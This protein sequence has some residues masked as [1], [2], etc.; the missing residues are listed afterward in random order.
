MRREPFP[1]GGE[2]TTLTGSDKPVEI[3]ARLVAPPAGILLCAIAV[4]VLV[5]AAGVGVLADISARTTAAIIGGGVAGAVGLAS[6]NIVGL[7]C[8]RLN[9][10]EVSFTN[11][12]RERHLT[13]DG[14]ITRIVDTE[15]N[16]GAFISRG[17]SWRIWLLVDSPGRGVLHLDHRLWDRGDLDRLSATLGL[18]VESRTKP[19]STR[20][21]CRE[22]PGAY[23]WW[24]A[25]LSLT[26]VLLIVAASVAL[27]AAGWHG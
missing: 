16:Y 20:D 14:P 11:G 22:F 15:L 25:H 9:G 5:I 23:A 26:T 4:A 17:R 18:P 19:T 27:V 12:V 10:A 2:T 3:R 7:W 24:Q 21:L 1:K 6:P 13:S 8:I